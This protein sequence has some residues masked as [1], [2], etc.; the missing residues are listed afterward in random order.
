VTSSWIKPKPARRT[1]E[2]LVGSRDLSAEAATATHGS[3]PRT[4]ISQRRQRRGRSISDRLADDLDDTEAELGEY[5]D[6]DVTTVNADVSDPDHVAAMVETAVDDL[7]D[8]DVLL[9]VAGMST[10]EE[11]ADLGADVW[12]LVQ[13]VN[14]RGGFLAAR[15]A[16]PHLVDGGRIV[17]VSSIA[18]LY[19]SATMSHYAAAKA[20][21][22]NVTTSLANEW[23]ADNVRVNAVAPG[24]TLTPG[25]V[26]LLEGPTPDAYD[27]T[28]IGRKIG[29]P[30]EIADTLLFLASPLSSFVTGETIRVAGRPP[31]QEDVSATPR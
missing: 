13:Q 23:A 10:L 19:G 6:V 14:L 26:G 30:A 29:S 1:T 5:F 12:D 17:N 2:R 11:S 27:R 21:V 9:N 4:V 8:L 20:G 15:E 25:S 24:P 3:R 31:V 22:K 16:Y 18:G 7:G 28:E